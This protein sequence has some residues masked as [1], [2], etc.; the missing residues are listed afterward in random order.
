MER[1][2]PGMTGI[3]PVVEQLE[4]CRTDAER[5]RW[6]L[7]VPTFIFYREQT[8]IFRVL[9]ASRFG[10]GEQLVDIEISSLLSVRDRFGRLPAEL[11]QMVSAARNAVAVLARK[12]GAA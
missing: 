9:R 2:G 8:N 1:K 4:E 3:L 5:A 11:D 12:G 6:L 10:L 7:S